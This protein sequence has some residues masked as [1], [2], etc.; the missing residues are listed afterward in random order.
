MW[1]RPTR[2]RSDSASST[3]A[4]SGTVRQLRRAYAGA[5]VRQ[6]S[7]ATATRTPAPQWSYRDRISS[8]TTSPRTS[9][10]SRATSAPMR[11]TTSTSERIPSFVRAIRSS[12]AAPRRSAAASRRIRSAAPAVY[13]HVKCTYIGACAG[14]AAARGLL[15]RR[16]A[17]ARYKSD[18]GTWTII[19]GDTAQSA[20]G[21]AATRYMFDLNDSLFTRGLQDRVLLHGPRQSRATNRRCRGG[22]A[23]TGPTS[24]SRASRRRTATFSSS[25][26]ATASGSFVGTAENYWTSD[27]RADI[28]PEHQP[29]RYDVNAPA[30]G[31]S[32]GPG[33]RAKSKQ[34]IDQYNTIVWDSGDLEQRHDHR[35]HGQ[36]R[37]VER[38]PDAHRLD[39]PVASTASVSGSA[40]TTSRTIW[41]TLASTPGAHPHEHLVRR[42]LRRDELLRRTG[43]RRAAAS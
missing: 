15:A 30:S 4:T 17:T 43:G 7:A 29:D 18:D 33:S 40:A 27:A 20:G 37:Q 12:S 26:T 2:Y 23:R 36:Q 41:T 19:Q 6:R 1:E 24:S 39:G 16:A 32:N 5:V 34:L 22:R 31:V 25:T 21:V 9:S 14:Q 8:R 35:R 38:L 13:M 28:S 11:R 42:R 3:C 10:I